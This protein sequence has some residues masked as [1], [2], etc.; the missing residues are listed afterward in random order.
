MLTPH[1]RRAQQRQSG[2]AL[3]ESLVAVVVMAF[4]VL[5][6]LGLQLR[7]M[8]NNQSANYVATAAR[9]ADG[10]FERV[11]SNPNANPSLNPTFD[12]NNPLNAAQWAWLATYAVNWGAT[13][14]VATDCDANFCTAAQRATWDIN[15]WKQ[16][17]TQTLP[18][19]EARVLVSP[20][21]PRQLIVVVGWRA[22]E[23]GASPLAVNIPGV[24]APTQCGTT[25]ACYFAYGQP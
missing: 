3:I 16:T 6:L 22:N 23:Q 14:V 2:I 20:D 5:G 4:G 21:N 15:R 17:V 12:P 11:K 13:T 1:P 18:N 25:H 9:V 19:G 24:T 7:T 8:A 10:L